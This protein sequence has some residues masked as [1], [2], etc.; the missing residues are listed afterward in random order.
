MSDLMPC[1]ALCYRINANCSMQ[2]IA[3]LPYNLP[4]FAML[5]ASAVAVFI[6]YVGKWDQGDMVCMQNN[7]IL[8]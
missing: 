3:A 5:V 2:S 1:A 4:F 7:L 6:S 8:C